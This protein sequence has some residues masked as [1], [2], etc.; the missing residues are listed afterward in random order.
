MPN[1][2]ASQRP[3]SRLF[4][5]RTQISF[6][7][8]VPTGD[9]CDRSSDPPSPPLQLGQLIEN[10]NLHNVVLPRH[11]KLGAHA[12]DGPVRREM[13]T[14]SAEKECRFKFLRTFAVILEAPTV[15]VFALTIHFATDVHTPCIP[16]CTLRIF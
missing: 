12:Q 2:L 15:P 7:V 13:T 8:H 5:T 16:Y 10:E 4:P 1:D 6:A 3:Q 14:S 9:G 11:V